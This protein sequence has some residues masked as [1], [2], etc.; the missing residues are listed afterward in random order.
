MS[1]TT[2]IAKSTIVLVGAGL[3]GLALLEKLS[4]SINP[5]KHS[6]IL[7]DARPA[8]MHLISTLRLIV[9]DSD[10]LLEKAIHPYGTHT[11]RNKFV[12]NA[13]FIHASVTEIKFGDSELLLNNGQ[14][15]KY[16]VLV[17]AT[18]S[19]WP[20]PIAF[21]NESREAIIEHVKSRRAEFEK[22][23]NILLVGGGAV[24]IEL[25]GELRDAFP[26]KP[27][28]IIHRERLLLNSTYPDKFRIRMQRQL[29][30]RSI[31]VLTDD[32][33]SDS[34]LASVSESQV[35]SAGFVSARG[36]KLNPDLVVPTWG[37]R[38]NTSY[39]PSS[40]LS[41]SSR[42]K[43]LPTF[44]LPDHPNVF[45]FGDIIDWDEQHMAGKAV[46]FHAPKVATNVML[47]LNLV[48]S[49]GPDAKVDLSASKKS[50]KY[51]GSFEGL[52]ITNGKASGLGFL[53]V[54]WG[55]TLSGW[56]VSMIKSK[57]LFV[58]GL[59]KVTGYTP[60]TSK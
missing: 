17:L 34:D 36:T 13:S 5:D 60:S 47:Y 53:D 8:L 40:V 30:T 4:T 3:G 20:R 51:T 26:T 12:G 31:A 9:S 35:P 58:S 39:L 44:Q 18:G 57:G 46:A 2:D 1:K 22:A 24:G 55:I 10:N 50:V 6:L 25:S 14:T 21:P 27:I 52:A 7:I 23:T 37:N 33:I 32:Y 49:A 43:I 29:E 45:A 11:F 28:T 19:V 16:D 42:V 38:P 15:V 54:L 59:S 48:E 56:V 41:S